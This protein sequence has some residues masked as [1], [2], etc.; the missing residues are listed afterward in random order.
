MLKNEGG[1]MMKKLITIVLTLT[2]L[3]SLSA[4]AFAADLKYDFSKG[5]DGW[6]GQEATTGEY[7]EGATI[8][9]SAGGLLKATL[10]AGDNVYSV[11]GPEDKINAGDTVTFHI[12]LSENTGM[13]G[14]QVFRM[15]A[16]YTDWQSEWVDVKPGEWH[17]VTFTIPEGETPFSKYGIQFLTGDG[18]TAITADEVIYIGSEKADIPAETDGEDEV[19]PKTGYTSMLPL[20][21]MAAT[22]GAVLIKRRKK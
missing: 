6:K 19:S 9:E 16:G 14:L 17:E 10:K 21:L 8:V 7:G 11:L 20:V 22:S 13:T 15:A 12:H 1:K 3:L 4:L 5:T 2:L 18:G